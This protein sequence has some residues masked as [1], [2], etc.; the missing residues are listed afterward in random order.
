[1]T[2]DYLATMYCR[3]DP[4][5]NLFDSADWPLDALV[6]CRN[7][8]ETAYRAGMADCAEVTTERYSMRWPLMMHFAYLA[9]WDNALTWLPTST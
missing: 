6:Y 3:N 7:S 8:A 4:P 9:G 2:S 5:S 1:M